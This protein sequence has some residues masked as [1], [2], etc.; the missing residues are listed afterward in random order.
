[1]S[2]LLADVLGRLAHEG[3]ET[4]DFAGANVPGIAEFKR[5][6]GGTLAPTFLVR[7]VRHPAL[8]LL[9]RLRP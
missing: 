6:F 2:V 9:D 3:A 8:R 4:F 7:T 5:K 1:M